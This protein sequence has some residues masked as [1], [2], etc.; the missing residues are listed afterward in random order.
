MMSDQYKHDDQAADNTSTQLTATICQE[1]HEHNSAIL[2]SLSST[3]LI[4][5]SI[6]TIRQLDL[7]RLIAYSSIAHMALVLAGIA[8]GS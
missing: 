6:L 1:A 2:Y 8:L 3:S 5:A 7:K 4:Y